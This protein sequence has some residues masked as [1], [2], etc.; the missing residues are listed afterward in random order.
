MG[1]LV[2][3]IA[4]DVECTDNFCTGVLSLYLRGLFVSFFEFGP[5]VEGGVPELLET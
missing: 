1:K 5:A 4:I 2:Y 3:L